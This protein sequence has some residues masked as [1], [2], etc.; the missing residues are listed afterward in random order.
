[1]KRATVLLFM[2]VCGFFVFNCNSNKTDFTE[3][4]LDENSLLNCWTKTIGDLNQ[5]GIDELVI[6]GHNGGGL[7]V[8][9]SPKLNKIQITNMPGLSTYAEVADIDNDVKIWLN[10][11]K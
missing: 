7:C 5:D 2:L 11:L 9:M 4:I 10:N 3:I 8:F 6:G 1:M